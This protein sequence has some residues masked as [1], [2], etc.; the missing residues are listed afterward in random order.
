MIVEF[1][2]TIQ[3]PPFHR[4]TSRFCTRI[5]WLLPILNRRH[6]SVPSYR[7]N[8]SAGP[9][10]FR[11]KTVS[12]SMRWVQFPLRCIVVPAPPG[13]ENPIEALQM[14]HVRP[15]SSPTRPLIQYHRLSFRPLRTGAPPFRTGAWAPAPAN[16][17]PMI[18]RGPTRQ[19]TRKASSS[20]VST[21][22]RVHNLPPNLKTMSPPR[23]P[24]PLHSFA[25]GRQ[26]PPPS[27][28]SRP[29]THPPIHPS[30]CPPPSGQPFSQPPSPP[31]SHPSRQSASPPAIQPA[32]PPARPRVTC[33]KERPL[34]SCAVPRISY[35]S[36]HC[37]IMNVKRIYYIILGLVLILSGALMALF[38]YTGYHEN[39][40]IEPIFTLCPIGVI[41]FIAGGIIFLRARRGN[42][43]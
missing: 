35:I 7:I 39:I 41:V 30:A 14:H 1:P 24:A 31:A 4:F 12:L 25:R 13:P 22:P 42:V 8:L 36:M 29:S 15:S 18:M 40:S 3:T 5:C 17:T 10:D 26:I 6:L 38:G 43:P 28:P 21:S 19:S 11:S 37:V 32:L 16:S 9:W 2:L 23:S 34:L 20:S 27:S 33:P